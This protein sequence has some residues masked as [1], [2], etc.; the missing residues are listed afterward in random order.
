MASSKTRGETSDLNTALSEAEAEELGL[1]T[2]EQKYSAQMR[3]IFPTKIDLPWLTLKTQI[4]QQ[5]DLRPEFQR[6]DRW[7]DEKRSRFIESVIMNV[8]VPPVFLGEER[9][10]QYVVLDGRQRLTAAYRFLNNQLRLEGLQ[11]WSELNGLTYEE[12]KKKGFAAT[13][14]RRFLS[15]IL[16]TRES[17]AEVKYEVFDR[18]NT[19]GIIAG[20]MEV[21]NAIFPGDFNALLHELS[22]EVGFRSLWAI[23]LGQDPVALERNV[24]YREMADLELVLRFFALRVGTLQ[25]MRFKDRLS[26]Y[27]K[28]R[29]ALYRGAPELR[30]QDAIVFRRAIENCHTVFGDDAFK[31]QKEPNKRANRSAPYADSVMQALADCAEDLLNPTAIAEIRKGFTELCLKNHDFRNAVEKGTNGESAIRNRITLA[32]A[33]VQSATAVHDP[34][35]T[36]GALKANRRVGKTP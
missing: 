20:P 18:L 27:M 11:V 8:P 22:A 30:D 26:D 24:L 14:E 25:G 12:I 10:G 4:D 3:Q 6:R 35:Q 5:I 9:Y 36:G 16:L 31:L 17:S 28:E 29:N 13:I 15:A 19:G 23:P 2:L 33:V 7:N 21:R 34:R 1:A 32:R